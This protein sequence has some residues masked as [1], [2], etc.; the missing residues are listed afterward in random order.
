MDNMY[1]VPYS[2][3]FSFTRKSNCCNKKKLPLPLVVMDTLLACSSFS[4]FYQMT[5]VNMISL[6]NKISLA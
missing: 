4:L 2:Y 6:L 5:A 3:L 1:S